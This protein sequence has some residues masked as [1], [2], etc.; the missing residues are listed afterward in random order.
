M[1]CLCRRDMVL[2]LLVCL[3]V[4]GP[5]KTASVHAPKVLCKTGKSKLFSLRI[6]QDFAVTGTTY[7]LEYV[8]YFRMAF[9]VSLSHVHVLMTLPQYCC[10]VT[11]AIKTYCVV[12][13]CWRF[14]QPS[15]PLSFML[16]TWNCI[17]YDVHWNAYST[18][19]TGMSLGPF[20]MGVFPSG[21]FPTD[22]S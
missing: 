6:F 13:W 21:N 12:C 5:S 16:S 3:S 7:S 9:F 17:K 1:L 4:H 18:T 11:V 14:P 2:D 8:V 15:F 19:F 22:Y 20:P 10:S